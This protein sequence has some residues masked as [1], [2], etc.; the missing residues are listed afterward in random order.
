MVG[1]TRP[2]RHRGVGMGRAHLLAG[3]CREGA[4]SRRAVPSVDLGDRTGPGT[5][6]PACP[7]M[8]P[9]LARAA[10]T[11]LGARRRDRDRRRVMTM[12]TGVHTVP[13]ETGSAGSTGNQERRGWF[14]TL[15][16]GGA[17]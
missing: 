3:L 4:G 7:S 10:H 5:T 8:P 15:F 14:T 9:H 13:P 1:G 17:S 11:E 6:T 12:S 2:A 16:G